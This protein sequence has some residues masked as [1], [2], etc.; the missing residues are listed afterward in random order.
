MEVE[1]LATSLGA[2]NQNFSSSHEST[3]KEK[4]DW[5][6]GEHAERIAKREGFSDDRVDAELDYDEDNRDS[7][8]FSLH[9]D[10]DHE[11]YHDGGA[12]LVSDDEV[13]VEAERKNN[14][15]DQSNGDNTNLSEAFVKSNGK[16][17]TSTANSAKKK[18]EPSEEG[19][20][21]DL[22]EGEL[23]SDSESDDEQNLD[24]KSHYELKEQRKT[25]NKG[26]NVNTQNRMAY[27]NSDNSELGSH[28]K[29]AWERGLLQARELMK[30]ATK[31]KEEP[32][33]EKKRLVLAPSEDMDRRTTDDDSDDS[34]LLSKNSMRC[35]ISPRRKSQNCNFSYND[36][37]SRQIRRH[38]RFSDQSTVDGLGSRNGYRN[39]HHFEDYGRFVVN[40]N[41]VNR[42]RIPSL[43]DGIRENRFVEVKKD[44]GPQVLY[45]NGRPGSRRRENN[46]RRSNKR[47][48]PLNE[49]YYVPRRVSRSPHS[50]RS[51]LRS[52][53]P[54]RGVLPVSRSGS[55]KSGP[56]R[57]QHN[58]GQ[59][60]GGGPGIRDP[61]DRSQRKRNRSR[62]LPPNTLGAAIHKARISEE[63]SRSRKRPR[64]TSI[65][66][67]SIPESSSSTTSRSTSSDRRRKAATKVSLASA[68]P[69]KN[70]FDDDG[71]IR[72]T[73]L[74]SFRIPKKKRSSR[75]P[76]RPAAVLNRSA[77][78]TH[79]IHSESY[80]RNDSQSSLRA[81]WQNTGSPTRNL[82]QIDKSRIIRNTDAARNERRLSEAKEEISSEESSSSSR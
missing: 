14:K 82:Q 7:E 37:R 33:F 26:R 71:S 22:E 69:L 31:K 45:P 40:Y 1:G 59:S 8:N 32:D 77:N 42:S 12:C 70:L 55:E 9:G 75:S 47:D 53:S 56:T 15:S 3:F 10:E 28:G 29:S 35:D 61:W 72:Q 4:K 27:A 64:S 48:M 58:I 2:D 20:I 80:S 62:D 41:S 16:E 38:D 5:G 6:F 44:L 21:D 54:R 49:R 76:S 18:R 17:A 39:D 52:L 60:L 36:S 19:E 30:K 51:P 57:K 43:M 78:K 63:R 25:A 73:D 79:S 46:I 34:R 68:V 81:R 11:G 74:S 13:Q 66:E 67:S 23:R 65:S 24:A 50:S